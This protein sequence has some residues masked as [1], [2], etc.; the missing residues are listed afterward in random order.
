[1]PN[2]LGVYVEKNLIK[3]AKVSRDKTSSL[4]NVLSY[5]VKF[6]ENLEETVRS[7]INETNSTADELCMNISRESFVDF[8]I[9]SNLKAKDI[10]DLLKTEFEGYCAEKGLIASSYDMRYSLVKNTNSADTYKAICVSANKA[11]L[12]AIWQMFENERLKSLSSMAFSITNIMK[13]KGV[14]E[15]CAVVN[16][17]DETTMTVI[18]KGEI[19]KVVTIPLGMQEII[20]RLSDRFNSY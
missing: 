11:E 19:S 7:I 6:Y 16:I 12:S 3:Y 13:D 8:N 5:G 9:F 17:E 15:Q 1:M 4:F 14:G 10:K 18:T 20:S 2:C